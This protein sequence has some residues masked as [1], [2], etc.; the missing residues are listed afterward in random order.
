L[1]INY[2]YIKIN[3]L[4]IQTKKPLTQTYYIHINKI[5]EKYKLLIV[6]V[7]V[8]LSSSCS[9]QCNN[10]IFPAEDRASV[11]NNTGEVYMSIINETA[12]H[13]IVNFLFEKGSRNY[14]HYHEGITQTLL[15]LS[16]EGYYQEHGQAKQKIKAGDVIVTK[17]GVHH[18]N[19]STTDSYLNCMTVTEIVDGEHVVQIRPV[20]DEEYNSYKETINTINNKQMERKTNIGSVLALYPTPVTLVGALVDG[21]VNWLIVSHVGIIG[22]DKIMLSMRKSHYTNKGVIKEGKLSVS[23]VDETS[24]KRVDYVGTISGENIDKSRL[25]EYELSENGVPLPL[26]LPL[27]MEC[28]VVDNYQ[29]DTFDNFICK[30]SNTYVMSEF[31]TENGKVNYEKLKPVLFEM[32]TYSYLQTGDI[33]AKCRTLN[34]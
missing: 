4:L 32:P 28:E 13:M 23:I 18:W 22:H 26:E 25:F 20:S 19:G 34:K 15:V 6:L 33:I 2:K 12:T 1:L 24:L 16:G 3:A 31:I 7:I 21:K 11:S 27:T 14:W 30:I 17:P 10:P 8:L 9:K 5:M 29:T